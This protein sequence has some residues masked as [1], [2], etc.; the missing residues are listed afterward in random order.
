VVGNTS[1]RDIKVIG[2]S[3]VPPNIDLTNIIGV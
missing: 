1:K 2:G 3:P